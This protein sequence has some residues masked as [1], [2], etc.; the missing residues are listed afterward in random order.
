[1]WNIGADLQADLDQKQIVP[2][3][4][5]YQ[6]IKPLGE[7]GMG[8]IYLAEQIKPIK[9]QVALKV[10]KPGMDTRRV[11][12]RFEAERQV[13]AILEHPNIARIY[14]AGM[15][16]IHLPYFVMEYV[17]G[18]PV[19]T[20]CD[21]EKLNIEER[22]KLFIQICQAI[23]YAHQKGIIHR[24]IKPSNVLVSTKNGEAVPKLIDFGI[25]KALDPNFTEETICTMAG[26]LIGTPEYMNPE[27][28]DLGNRDIDTLSDIY[29]L[30]VLLYELLTGTLP[31]NPE[32]LRKAAFQEIQRIICEQDP[33]RPS[34]LL[35][36]ETEETKTVAQKRH[37]VL[38]NLQ[39]QLHDELEWIP[40]KA[41]RKERQQRYQT[42]TEMANDIYNYLNGNPLIAGPESTSYRVKKY[43]IKHKFTST[44]VGLLVIILIAFSCTSFS[45]YLNETR[46]RQNLELA[47]YE[48]GSQTS[49]LVAY[50]KARMFLA[51]LDS[52]HDENI[53]KTTLYFM[54]GK[55]KLAVQY[56]TESGSSYEE[57]N[58][59]I[60][61]TPFKD[62]WF[63]HFII[64]EQMVKKKKYADA[65]SYYS[66]SIQMIH[67]LSDR[68]QAGADWYEKTIKSRLYD[69]TMMVQTET[70]KETEDTLQ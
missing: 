52:W 44:V 46:A 47:R 49:D 39:R 4:P 28:A 32:T 2:N 62:L 26:Q 41:L 20:Y 7:G 11:L 45:L 35:S 64:A 63:T 65:M 19:T 38:K 57:T 66:R 18:I 22:L 67:E 53:D 3:I 30:G 37:I 69:L 43:L 40:L 17:D 61:D 24:D 55:E 48:L 33:P 12:S 15:T 51:F 10:I 14:D 50:G 54:D 16:D 27:Q 13:L 60:K 59:Y 58:K 34:I 21:K 6:I 36:T 70:K 56:L 5:N 9:R 31:F 1:L 25:A 68:R 42:A 8:I 23:H 29:S